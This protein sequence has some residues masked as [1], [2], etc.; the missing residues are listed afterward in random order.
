MAIA[1]EAQV[2]V[3]VMPVPLNGR[4]PPIGCQAWAEVMPMPPTAFRSDHP[5][6]AGRR[7]GGR[8]RDGCE[9]DQQLIRVLARY[10][11]PDVWCGGSPS[12]GRCLVR[13]DGADAGW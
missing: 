12:P 5:L 13:S 10:T 3:A 9:L 1:I 7:W 2:P 4:D 6:A 11:G 8:C